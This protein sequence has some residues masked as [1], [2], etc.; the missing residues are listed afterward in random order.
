MKKIL[1]A[2]LSIMSIQL[3]NAKEEPKQITV[4][5]CGGKISE[6]VVQNGPLGTTTRIKCGTNNDLVC[7][8]YVKTVMVEAGKEAIRPNP[9]EPIE[10]GANIQIL[11][12]GNVLASGIVSQSFVNVFYPNLGEVT[13]IISLIQ[14]DL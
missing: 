5:V 12:E 13:H 8:T 1:F 3:I 7:F 14:S 2:F 4:E 6:E 11:I 9:L 10:I